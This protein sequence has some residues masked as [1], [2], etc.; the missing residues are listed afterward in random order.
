MST[1]GR[2]SEGEKGIPIVSPAA[3][4]IAPRRMLANRTT[5][6]SYI[7]PLCD[8]PSVLTRSPHPASQ[9]DAI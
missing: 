7:H 2:T 5:R 8:G 3:S 4:K 6:R 1:D 9:P